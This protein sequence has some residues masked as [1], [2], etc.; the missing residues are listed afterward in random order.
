MICVCFS[1]IMGASF[2]TVSWEYLSKRF[3][4][5]SRK[6]C[7]SRLSSIGLMVGGSEEVVALVVVEVDEVVGLEEVV[8]VLELDEVVG[9]EEVVLELD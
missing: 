2:L 3:L 9:L 5:S 7:L 4:S 1:I 8:V 6:F